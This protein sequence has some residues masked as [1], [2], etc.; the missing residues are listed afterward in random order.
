MMIY[1][2]RKWETILIQEERETHTHTPPHPP[3]KI[4]LSSLLIQDPPTIRKERRQKD[5]MP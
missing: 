2:G 5:K 3:P 4:S 1:L